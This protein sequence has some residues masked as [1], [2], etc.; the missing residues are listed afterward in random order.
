MNKMIFGSGCFVVMS[1]FFPL[2]ASSF[3]MGERVK[4]NNADAGLNAEPEVASTRKK[5]YLNKT[6]L[7][8][9]AFFPA[10]GR[11]K[12]IYGDVGLSVQAEAA[13]TS[14]RRPNVEIWEN[15]EWIFMDGN[16]IRS[17]GSTHIDILNVSL[18]LK[19]IGKVFRDS[20]F[21][22][23]GIGPDVG[24]VFIENEMRCCKDCHKSKIKEHKFRAGIGGILKTGAQVYFTRHFYL[25]LFADYL[26][27]PI[28]FGRDVNVGGAK[29]GGGLGARF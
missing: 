29:V 10:A 28:Q 27:L 25:D 14:K 21:L 16:P 5:V 18:G 9:A 11:F 6:E 23:A 4:R 7:R 24:F 26:Y 2:S 17:C 20:L 19:A 8:S 15:V 3:R 1:L 12:K 13:R 22:Y